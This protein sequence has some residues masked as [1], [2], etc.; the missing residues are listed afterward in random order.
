VPSKLQNHITKYIE[1]FRSE[2]KKLLCLEH[3]LHCKLLVVAMLS[4][5]AE[6]RYPRVDRDKA[7]FVKLIETYADWPDATSVSVHQLEMQIKKL[8]SAKAPGLSKNF[9]NGLSH[10]QENWQHSRDRGE[11]SPHSIDPK[12]ESILPETPSQEEKQLVESMKH[13]S[14]LYQYRCK[15]V[16]EFREPGYGMEFDQGDEKPYYLPMKDSKG[17]SLPTELVYPTQWFLDLPLPILNG[18]KTYYNTTNKNPYD[19]Y[20]FGSPWYKKKSN[21]LP[22]DI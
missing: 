10:R 20:A 22:H 19:S 7:K 16:H 5:L 2:H 15:L 8:R 18:L 14:L 3:R 4:A 12:P 9:V 17:A 1:H 13:A 21:R 11:I 6:G